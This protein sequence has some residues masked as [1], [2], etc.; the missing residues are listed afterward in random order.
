[1]GSCTEKEKHIRSYH[2]DLPI[3]YE[4][5]TKVYDNKPEYIFISKDSLYKFP[6]I[7]PEVDKIIYITY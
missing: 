3:D 2:P 5:S 6:D 1:M 7:N 4:N